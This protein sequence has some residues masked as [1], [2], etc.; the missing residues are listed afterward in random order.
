MMNLTTRI[1]MATFGIILAVGFCG[2]ASCPCETACAPAAANANPLKVAVFADK[3]PSGVGAVEW[4]RLVND[5]PDMTLKIVD[6]E[7]VRNGALEGQDL[8]IMPGGSS[9]KEYESLGTNGVEKMKA[10]IRAGGAYFGTCAGCC[11]LMDG[12]NR[13]HVIPWNTR[14]AESDLLFPN[15]KVNAAGAKALGIKE[16]DHRFRYHGGPFMWPTTNVIDGAKFE[17]WATVNSEA[18]YCGEI[19]KKKQMFGA[20]AIVGGTY[21]KGRV[22]VTS[23]HPEYFESTHYLVRAGI[24][25][26]TGR[27]VALRR[28]PRQRGDLAVG[29]FAICGSVKS[30]EASLELAAVDGID[31]QVMNANDILWSDRLAHLDVLIVPGGVSEK[32]AQLRAEVEAFI[33][34]GG[35]FISCRAKNAPKGAVICKDTQGVIQKV[36]ELAH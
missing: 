24:R 32:N 29:C 15:V 4:Y 12:K 30:V 3:G 34:R 26:L 21:G 25:Y 33:A 2:C 28:P 22:F 11:L 7:Q 1:G 10:F 31:L 36:R 5:S 14:G 23:M 17:L 6:G 20:A 35:V 9:K 13:A 16:G 27:D 19:N 18:T 8:L